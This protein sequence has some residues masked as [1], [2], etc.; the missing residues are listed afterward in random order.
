MKRTG[1][2]FGQWISNKNWLY[3]QEEDAWVNAEEEYNNT[4][5]TNDAVWDLFQIE[6]GVKNSPEDDSEAERR[7]R[8][9][10]K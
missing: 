5:Y 4:Q 10:Y 9:M 3:L 6:T 1:I 7:I 2:A 8:G